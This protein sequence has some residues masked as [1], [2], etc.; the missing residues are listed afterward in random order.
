MKGKSLRVKFLT[1]VP[2]FS[3]A[4]TGSRVLN[5]FL[6]ELSALQR[7]RILSYLLKPATP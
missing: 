3:F 4:Y 7:H 5:L 1:T 2:E 6:A